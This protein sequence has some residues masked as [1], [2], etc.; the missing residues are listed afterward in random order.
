MDGGVVGM[1]VALGVV[2]KVAGETLVVVELLCGLVER[3][4]VGDVRVEGGGGEG[5]GGRFDV[6]EFLEEGVGDGFR[7]PC[8]RGHG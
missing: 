1:D 5:E 4:D 2:D 6:E 8:R 7:V 3:G